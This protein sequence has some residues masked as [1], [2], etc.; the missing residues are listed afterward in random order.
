[1]KLHG[2]EMEVCS[3]NHINIVLKKFKKFTNKMVFIQ[4]R[5]TYIALIIGNYAM[6]YN[7][8]PQLGMYWI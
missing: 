3:S 5:F 4:V 2:E 7:I 6:I 1:M 8:L